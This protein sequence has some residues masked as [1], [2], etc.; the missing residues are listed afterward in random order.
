VLLACYYYMQSHRAKGR[1]CLLKFL[2]RR[3]SE[4][5]F[6]WPMVCPHMDC[7]TSGVASE[8]RLETGEY[9]HTTIHPSTNP[10]TCT[11][12][13]TH[14]ETHT[15]TQHTFIH[16]VKYLCSSGQPVN[17]REHP[18]QVMHARSGMAGPDN[19]VWASSLTGRGGQSSVMYKA[20]CTKCQEL[21]HRTSILVF[22]VLVAPNLR[23]RCIE[24]ELSL[25]N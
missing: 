17:A 15:H 21:F 8:I 18:C 24:F 1:S 11:Y 10:Y 7:P 2:T 25:L 23:P 6:R 20:P 16:T 19:A 22:H 9:V 4:A 13:H 3:Q 12:T 5:T 14:T